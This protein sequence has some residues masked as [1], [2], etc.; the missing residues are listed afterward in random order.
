MQ[1]SEIEN[2]L[3]NLP[4]LRRA[5]DY[6]YKFYNDLG[7]E[8]REVVKEAL[9]N[10]PSQPSNVYWR[11]LGHRLQVRPFNSDNYAIV[12]L[13]IENPD[14]KS[15]NDL[16]KQRFVVQY[17]VY[18]KDC[19]QNLRQYQEQIRVDAFKHFRDERSDRQIRFWE[20]AETFASATALITAAAEKIGELENGQFLEQV[21]QQAQGQ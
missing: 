3:E 19:G 21:R 1:V 8:V 9:N 2:T 17:Y 10:E 6:Y 11:G 4:V 15:N 14:F 20:S 12:L 18:S 7:L 13:V 16:R 5:K